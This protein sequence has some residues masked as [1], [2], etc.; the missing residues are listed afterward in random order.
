MQTHLACGGLNGVGSDGIG[1]G[2]LALEHPRNGGDMFALAEL[3]LQLAPR[4]PLLPGLAR[5]VIGGEG[6]ADDKA[7]AREPGI[8]DATYDIEH[9]GLDDAVADRL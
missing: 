8:E 3:C 4:L 9:A 6:W 2:D 5:H 7:P 1:G